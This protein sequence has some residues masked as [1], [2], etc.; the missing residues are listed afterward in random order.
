MNRQPLY[1]STEC[2][3][4]QKSNPTVRD[5]VS[6]RHASPSAS[7]GHAHATLARGAMDEIQ[8]RPL[9]SSARVAIIRWVGTHATWAAVATLRSGAIVNHR[10]T[11]SATGRSTARQ[12]I[13]Y[14]TRRAAPRGGRALPLLQTLFPFPPASAASRLAIFC[15]SFTA[16]FSAFFSALALGERAAAGP[17]SG[18]LPAAEAREGPTFGVARA[19]LRPVAITPPEPK[20]R[21][22]T[23]RG[24]E[25]RVRRA[26][27]S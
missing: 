13:K 3:T 14:A 8:A 4:S 20:V 27:S 15:D 19:A 12:T 7:C 11:V 16:S 1:L 6:S 26:M 21:L 2:L 10:P 22:P 18:G 17:E 24:R 23:A 9:A 5:S 25:P